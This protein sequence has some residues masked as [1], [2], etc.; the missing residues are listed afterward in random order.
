MRS[1]SRFVVD[2]RAMSLA[3]SRDTGCHFVTPG[4]TQRHL[5]RARQAERFLDPSGQLVS[6]TAGTKL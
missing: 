5:V 1:V 3:S 4:A 6:E 2:S